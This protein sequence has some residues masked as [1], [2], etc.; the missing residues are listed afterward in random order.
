MTDEDVR[1]S[2]KTFGAAAQAI[3]SVLPLLN[4]DRVGECIAHFDAAADV[5]MEENLSLDDLE[6]VAALDNHNLK[7]CIA[8]ILRTAFI[9]GLTLGTVITAKKGRS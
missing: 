4:S 1:M 5:W 9:E 3:R 7:S 8:E 6:K 2:K